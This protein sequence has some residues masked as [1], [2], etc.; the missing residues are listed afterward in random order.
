VKNNDEEIQINNTQNE[1]QKVEKANTQKALKDI[2]PLPIQ[3]EFNFTLFT[4]AVPVTD[5]M[6]IRYCRFMGLNQQSVS[7]YPKGANG[8]YQMGPGVLFFVQDLKSNSVRNENDGKHEND[9]KNDNFLNNPSN[10]H[11]SNSPE[12]TPT[13]NPTQLSPLLDHTIP[14]PPELLERGLVH[15]LFFTSGG[16]AVK[17]NT[18]LIISTPQLINPNHLCPE[19]ISHFLQFSSKLSNEILKTYTTTSTVNPKAAIEYGLYNDEA[20]VISL[21]NDV[22][23][24]MNNTAKYLEQKQGLEKH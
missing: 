11:A 3:P 1:T 20:Y 18:N 24:A 5:K 15:H 22:A 10:I 16:I 12:S 4:P 9:E 14:T 8:T 2:K 17:K 7:I 6:P 19:K 13:T 23:I 21:L